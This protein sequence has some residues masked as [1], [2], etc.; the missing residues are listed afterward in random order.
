[1]KFTASDRLMLR[2]DALDARLREVSTEL[3]ARKGEAWQARDRLE[4]VCAEALMQGR[5][6]PEEAGAL[7]TDLRRHEAAIPALEEQETSLKRLRLEARRDHLRQ[8]RKEQPG[9]WIVLE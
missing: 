6:R 4:A 5:P 7:E 9:R 2:V 1:M 3:S 8:L